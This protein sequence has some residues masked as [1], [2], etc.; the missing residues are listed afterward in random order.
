MHR[1]LMTK[2]LR[3]CVFFLLS[4]VLAIACKQSSINTNYGNAALSCVNANCVAV[5][6]FFKTGNNIGLPL[7]VFSQNGGKSFSLSAETPLPK[8]NADPQKS[9]QLYSV[10][11]VE[12][13]CVAV[14]YYNLDELSLSTALPLI[15]S[16]QNSGRTF[17]SAV[18]GPTP[19]DAD[20][21]KISAFRGISSSGKRWIAVG[22][23]N[24]FVG[25]PE[26]SLPFIS[27]TDENGMNFVHAFQPPLPSNFASPI[28]AM[29]YNVDCGM[30]YCTAVGSYSAIVGINKILQPLILVSTDDGES[31]N[32]FAQIS[33]LNSVD[34][35]RDMELRSVSCNGLKCF[36]V[37]YYSST[38]N[39]GKL[40]LIL[41]SDDGGLNFKMNQTPQL[42]DDA[43]SAKDSELKT[44]DCLGSHCVAGG[45]YNI[46]E[47]LNPPTAKALSLFSSNAGETFDASAVPLPLGAANNLASVIDGVACKR[48]SYIGVGA[49]NINF[50]PSSESASPLSVFS[51]SAQETEF[52]ATSQPNL[53]LGT[54][55]SQANTL[56]DVLP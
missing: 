5:G 19:S 38:N 41:E 2:N 6:Q 45:Y 12:K 48:N 56:G 17:T 3:Y 49:Y 8:E 55:L 23:Y 4:S 20:P 22:T 21:T 39:I 15:V 7:A 14:G 25:M 10:H 54:D 52:T 35:T 40:P 9:S 28:L 37:G 30:Q 44:I 13:N 47:S 31:F 18:Q 29:L 36:A 50:S 51:A 33:I 1:N 16:S 27:T 26:T 46:D 32:Q 11:C 34:T 53:P 24:L 42:P 43:D